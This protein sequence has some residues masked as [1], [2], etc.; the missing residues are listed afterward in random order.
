MSLIFRKRMA[1]NELLS[2]FEK[3]KLQ[4]AKHESVIILRASIVLINH[5]VN[6]PLSV[7]TL[8]A[9][10]KKHINITCVDI[11]RNVIR[12]KDKLFGSSDNFETVIL[13]PSKVCLLQELLSSCASSQIVAKDHLSSF[14]TTVAEHK[15]EVKANKN[16]LDFSNLCGQ[17]FASDGTFVPKFQRKNHHVGLPFNVPGNLKVKDGDW[18]LVSLRFSIKADLQFGCEIHTAKVIRMG[19]KKEKAPASASTSKQSKVPQNVLL[20]SIFA[21]ILTASHQQMRMKDVLIFVHSEMGQ[22]MTEEELFQLLLKFPALFHLHKETS[23]S[24]VSIKKFNLNSVATYLLLGDNV[25]VVRKKKLLNISE[26]VPSSKGVEMAVKQSR[27]ETIMSV[28]NLSGFL[29]TV[30]T[31]DGQ[32]T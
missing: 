26:K 9:K 14:H 2:P 28:T 4:V 22:K 18:L 21:Q 5:D 1:E 27:T 15:F 29:Q 24:T 12:S 25:A 13:K 16:S 23:K 19:S 6:D 17:Y 8:F 7:E 32:K 11:F 3:M 20:H 10:V 30:R 31:S